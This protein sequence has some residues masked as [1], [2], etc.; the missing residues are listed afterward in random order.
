[1]KKKAFDP[2]QSVG[3]GVTRILGRFTPEQ[4]SSK[5]SKLRARAEF[6]DSTASELLSIIGVASVVLG[7]GVGMYASSKLGGGS[8]GGSM[9]GSAIGGLLGAA[10][11]LMNPA[12]SQAQAP[13]SVV[14]QPEGFDLKP[15]RQSE[16]L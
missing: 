6:G 12:K 8:R 16:L 15:W 3:T 5:L 14:A 10:P 11:S 2:L 1:M 7:A 13:S 4:W 9:L